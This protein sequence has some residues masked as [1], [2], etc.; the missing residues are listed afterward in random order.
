MAERL[1][2]Y[3]VRSGIAVL[4]LAN[5]PANCYGYEMMRQLD[6]AI[7]GARF[8]PAVHVLLLRGQGKICFGLASPLSCNTTSWL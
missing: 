1:V 6:D 3:E 5:P 2:H 7:L 4:E 8:D